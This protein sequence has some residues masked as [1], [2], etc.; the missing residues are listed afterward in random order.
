MAVNAMPKQVEFS[1]TI[2]QTTLLELVSAEVNNDPAYAKAWHNSI[3]RACVEEGLSVPQ[4]AKIAAGFMVGVFALE[5]E[6]AAR[7]E[8]GRP[9][10]P[11]HGAIVLT[12]EAA[13]HIE[14]HGL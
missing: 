5:A 11:N 12:E 2:P 9:L 13:E 6:Q 14:R 4:A 7:I 3:V 8:V 10:P 1:I